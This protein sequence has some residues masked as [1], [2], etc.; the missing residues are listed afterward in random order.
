[1]ATILAS[2]NMN[3]VE[4]AKR[5]GYTGAVEFLANLAQMNDFLQF[6]PW[7]PA[8]DGNYHKYLEAKRLGKGAFRAANDNVPSISSQSDFNETTVALYEADSEVEE[9]VISTAKDPLAA[10]DSEDAANLEGFTQGWLEA[11]IYGDNSFDAF[12][13][14]ASRRASLDNSL[15]FGGGGTGSTNTSLWLFEFGKA[16]FNLRYPAGMMPGISSVDR[17]LHKLPVAGGGSNW[18]WVR[19]Y[20]IA[21][22]IETK[23]EKAMLRL[24][25]IESTGSDFPMAQFIKMKNQLPSLGRNAM[26]FA[27]RDLHALIENHAYAKSNMAYSIVDVKDFGPVL[28]I[29]NVPVMYMETLKNTE[30]TLTA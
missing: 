14:L 21:A 15:T 6:A 13:G 17:G 26:A 23:K 25:N 18:R 24:A 1:M 4:A 19:N 20:V 29:S 5:A 2:Q 22:A 8:S 28:R 11:L 10:R 7:F 27:N 12:R 30:T 16:G 9:R 3:I